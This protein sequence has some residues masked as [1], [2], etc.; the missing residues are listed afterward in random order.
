MSDLDNKLIFESYS[1]NLLLEQIINGKEMV[2]DIEDVVFSDRNF[3]YSKAFRKAFG[4]VV[5]KTLLKA[6]NSGFLDQFLDQNFKTG[7][8]NIGKSLNRLKGNW[9]WEDDEEKKK[10]F[11]KTFNIKHPKDLPDWMFKKGKSK[12]LREDI[13]KWIPINPDYPKSLEDR[14]RMGNR[15]NLRATRGSIYYFFDYIMSVKYH[16]HPHADYIG[17]FRDFINDHRLNK[18]NADFTGIRYAHSPEGVVEYFLKNPVEQRIVK[19]YNDYNKFIDLL[20]NKV[21]FETSKEIYNDPKKV[22]L[23]KDYGNGWKWVQLL[24]NTAC[25]ISGDLMGHC[26]GGYD[27][28][29][30]N[31]RLLQ[32][33]GPNG[34][35]HATIQLSVKTYPVATQKEHNNEVSQ[36]KGKSNTPLK[37][38]YENMV[39]DLLSSYKDKPL[40]TKYKDREG[41]ILD[42]SAT[43]N[44]PSSYSYR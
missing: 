12:K 15:Y 41:K 13:Y 16:D 39:K 42:F 8:E 7:F 3:P 44:Q 2:D 34:D 22:L 17:H 33:V 30:P 29:N 40:T 37:P 43:V 24:S 11:E 10:N 25:K 27:P 23:L 35:G 1:R 20:H 36:I 14:A 21:N 28:L 5:A 32:L 9:A 26:V 6:V 31:S 18:Q 19:I 4:K 38:E